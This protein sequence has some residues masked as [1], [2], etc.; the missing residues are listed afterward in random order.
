M[1]AEALEVHNM[2]E[3]AETIIKSGLLRKESRSYF[4][5][6]DYPQTDKVPRMIVLRLMNGR[7]QWRYEPVEL[8][9]W[10]AE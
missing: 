2:L 3:M 4:F 5:R 7:M 9:Y 10:K 1:W 8:K 6:S